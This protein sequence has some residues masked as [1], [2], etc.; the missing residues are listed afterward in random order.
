MK[1]G[2]ITIAAMLLFVCTSCSKLF[3]RKDDFLTI[4]QTPYTGDEIRTD[5]FYYQTWDDGMKYA[6]ITFLYNNGVVYQ[7]HGS[8]DLNKLIEYAN[9]TLLYHDTE[10]DKKGFWGL[11]TVDNNR[12]VYERWQGSQKGYLVYREEGDII[13]DTTFV[14][15]EVSRM[16]QGE[17]TETKAIERT[18]CFK[19]FSPKPDSTNNVIP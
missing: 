10:K 1:K 7:G 8:G 2:I 9:K 4:P 16:N 12:I 18:Y 11:F 5:G 19:E 6:E 13:N 14:M 17:K 15:T 3:P